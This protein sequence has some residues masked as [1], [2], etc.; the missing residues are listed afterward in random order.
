MTGIFTAAATP[1]KPRC[2]RCGR[3]FVP[4]KKGD[5]YGPKCARK[6]AGQVELDSQALVSGKV[7][8]KGKEK[9]VPI[10]VKGEKGEVTAVIV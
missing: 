8:R 1:G 9:I 5:R 10:Y 7:L 6:L 4:K 2:A 3:P